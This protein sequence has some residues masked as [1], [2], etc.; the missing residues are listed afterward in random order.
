LV[1]LDQAGQSG[2]NNEECHLKSVLIVLPASFCQFFS[3][4]LPKNPHGRAVIPPANRSPPCSLLFIIYPL[5]FGEVE[6]A[7]K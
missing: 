7:E 6:C 5:H 3:P 1:D 2:Q 4:E